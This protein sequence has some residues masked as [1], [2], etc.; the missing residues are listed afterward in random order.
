MISLGQERDQARFALNE[1][2]AD[3]VDK[4]TQLEDSASR[5]DQ[6][7]AAKKGEHDE[8]QSLAASI[9]QDRDSLRVERKALR[10][11]VTRLRFEIDDLKGRLRQFKKTGVV[12][13]ARRE[14]EKAPRGG[15]LG[16]VTSPFKKE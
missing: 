4:Q 1:L 16:R 3:L 14:P 15:L 11:E 7:R 6:E 9:G 12:W 10:D 8:L 2:Q 13:S 5:F